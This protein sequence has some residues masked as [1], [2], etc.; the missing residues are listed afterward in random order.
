LWGFGPAFR[1]LGRDMGFVP[2]VMGGCLV[3]YVAM[4][5]LSGGGFS[6]SLLSFMAPSQPVLLI[7]GASGAYPVFGLGRWWTVF[8][9]TWLHA[10][11]LHIILNMMAVRQLGP[12]VAEFYGAGRMV[13]IYTLAGAIGFLFSSIFG[14][15]PPILPFLRGAGFTVGAS[16]SICGLLGALVY[17]G[18][19]GGSSVVRS[20]AM[21][22]MATLLAMG[23]LVPGIDNFAHGGGFLGGYLI[24]RILDPLKPERID[25]L[26]IAVICL[27]ASLLSIVGPLLYTF[28]V[29]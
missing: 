14:V 3:V 29:R 6:G 2:V 27:V 1:D 8:S 17:Y 15:L 11:L 9:A 4:V 16:A 23:L 24:A 22:W 5:L 12:L 25:H 10:S 19:R 28:L 13:I 26:V 21:S 20:Q 7:F 18:R